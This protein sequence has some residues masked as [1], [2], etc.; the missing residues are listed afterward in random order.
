MSLSSHSRATSQVPAE[1]PISKGPL[2][3]LAFR[4]S[5]KWSIGRAYG[6]IITQECGVF[7]VS[8]QRLRAFEAFVKPNIVSCKGSSSQIR[9][10]KIFE[11]G[12]YRYPV[13]KRDVCS[14]LLPLR[15]SVF[16]CRQTVPSRWSD[17]SSEL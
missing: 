10:W 4:S 9:S 8:R 1:F 16:N 12:V 17:V 3:W 5:K 6:G 13:C 15:F 14:M 11:Q 7:E 2:T